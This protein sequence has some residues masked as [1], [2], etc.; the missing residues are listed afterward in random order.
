MRD[1][2]NELSPRIPPWNINRSIKFLMLDSPT[3]CCP[4]RAGLPGAATW[5]VSKTIHQLIVSAA[6]HDSWGSEG[7]RRREGG[8]EE[9]EEEEGIMDNYSHIRPVRLKWMIYYREVCW[10]SRAGSAPDIVCR[11]TMG[12][13]HSTLGIVSILTRYQQQFKFHTNW[14]ES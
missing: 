9:E 10:S 13:C 6:S 1:G 8:R 5:S 4:G 3:L 7:G 11:I 2:D 12:D 14:S